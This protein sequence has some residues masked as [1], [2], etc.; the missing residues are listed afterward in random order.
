MGKTTS[1]SRDP[2]RGLRLRLV[3]VEEAAPTQK[4]A[5]ARLW[6][7]LLRDAEVR[8]QQNPALVD[9]TTAARG[10]ER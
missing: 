4:H 9:E 10:N 7:L 8:T 3:W 5:W 1:S 6:Q 2:R